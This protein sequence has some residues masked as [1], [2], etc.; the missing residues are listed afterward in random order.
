MVMIIIV[1]SYYVLQH[2]RCV[3]CD[4]FLWPHYSP[5]PLTGKY[6]HPNI[7]DAVMKAWALD[8]T[9]HSY[10]H[11]QQIILI[12][13][14]E[15]QQW[16]KRERD[17]VCTYICLFWTCGMKKNTVRQEDEK[18]RSFLWEVIKTSEEISH[19]D[20]EWRILRHKE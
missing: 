9:I 1:I 11:S 8:T 10:I 18:G 6:N 19:E 2:V 20:T 16:S 14:T 15:I 7:T 4:T 17:N 13:G 12:Q 5:T 3:W